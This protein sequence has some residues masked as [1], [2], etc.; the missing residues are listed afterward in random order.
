MVQS[1]FL[2]KQQNLFYLQLNKQ[3]AGDE[4]RW[5]WWLMVFYNYQYL[6]L[7]R[8][9]QNPFCKTE[10]YPMRDLEFNLILLFLSLLFLIIRF[11][12]MP[13]LF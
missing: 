10:M 4:Q 9:L 7:I 8:A 13:R 1:S 5:I 11:L 2:K 12:H 3:L 6:I